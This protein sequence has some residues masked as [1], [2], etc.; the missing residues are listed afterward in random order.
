MLIAELV[1]N[2]CWPAL[3]ELAEQMEQADLV[4]R[5]RKALASEREH[6][7]KVRSWIALATGR[8]VERALSAGARF[9]GTPTSELEGAGS[10]A[11][12]T[13]ARAKNPPSGKERPAARGRGTTS[14][15]RSSRS[16]SKGGKTKTKATAP[17]KRSRTRR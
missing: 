13:R 11:S 9:P 2:D 1:D 17:A 16:Q 10:E 3:I 6:L 12:R 15:A 7:E 14:R 8:S 4:A 5:F